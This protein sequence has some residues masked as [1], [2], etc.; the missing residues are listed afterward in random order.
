MTFRFLF[1]ACGATCA[2][3]PLAPL[4]L[5]DAIRLAWSNDPTVAALALTPALAHAREEQAVIRPNPEV[6]FRGAKPVRGDCKWIVGVGLNQR[7][8]RRERVE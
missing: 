5:D 2:A 7:L 6:E 3:A 8:P 1:L 4:A